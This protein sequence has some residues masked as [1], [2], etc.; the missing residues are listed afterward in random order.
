MASQPRLL[1]VAAAV[2]A[3]ALLPGAHAELEACLAS[4]TQLNT[5][6]YSF[7]FPFLNGATGGHASRACI[8]SIGL[9]WFGLG[10][11]WWDGGRPDRSLNHPAPTNATHS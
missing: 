3:A 2:A 7:A 11:V 1:A 9:V 5:A 4:L 10:P 8:A 6:P